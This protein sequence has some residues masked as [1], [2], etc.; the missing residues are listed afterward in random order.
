MSAT[1]FG[2]SRRRIQAKEVTPGNRYRRRLGSGLAVTATVL[3]LRADL[4]GIMHVHFAIAVGR[5][6]ARPSERDTRVL[7]LQ[8][9]LDT[10]RE[11]VAQD[12]QPDPDGLDGST[13]IRLLPRPISA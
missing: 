7:A 5:S 8:S 10:Y 1:W 9:F 6:V 3:D 13:V 2:R 11:R 4:V 12:T